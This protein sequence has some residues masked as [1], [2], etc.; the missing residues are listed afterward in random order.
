MAP[1]QLGRAGHAFL[2]MRG[3]TVTA[4][5]D[6]Y[7]KRGQMSMQAATVPGPEAENAAHQ[8]VNGGN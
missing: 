6:I 1:R 8:M 7:P 3:E 4:C 5:I 2:F